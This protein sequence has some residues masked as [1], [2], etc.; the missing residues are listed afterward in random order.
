MK[1]GTNCEERRPALIVAEL[2]G[3]DLMLCQITSRHRRDGYSITLPE[4]G[5]DEGGLPRDSFIRPNRLFTAHYR[6]ILYRSG[7]LSDA[8]M[9]SVTQRLIEILSA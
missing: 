7:S 6:L 2:E 8:K 4:T 1:P 3:D 9:E 5:F